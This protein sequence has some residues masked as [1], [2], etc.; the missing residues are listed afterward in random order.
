MAVTITTIGTQGEQP[1][2][3]RAKSIYRLPQT[4]VSTKEQTTPG[5]QNQAHQQERRLRP[6]EQA[7]A[8]KCSLP[9]FLHLDRAL[10]LACRPTCVQV[11]MVE[12]QRAVRIPLTRCLRTK[13]TSASRIWLPP[14]V[15]EE[16]R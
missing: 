9:S 7:Q 10:S 13:T 8:T 16:G 3:S 11:A 14:P 1:I 15:F 4:R 5:R 6:R 2:L 12:V